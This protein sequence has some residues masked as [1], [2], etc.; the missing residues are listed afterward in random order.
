MIEPEPCRPAA[1][2]DAALPDPSEIQAALAW[3]RLQSSLTLTWHKRALTSLIA[4]CREH[5][6]SPD[7]VSERTMADYTAWLSARPQ[8][9]WPHWR[10]REAK[11]AWNIQVARNPQWPRITLDPNSYGV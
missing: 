3:A 11:R 2:D 10:C 5:G 9:R 1:R 7:A 4:Y 6:I 8:L